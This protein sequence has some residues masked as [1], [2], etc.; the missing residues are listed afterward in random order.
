MIALLYANFFKKFEHLRN[1]Q[2]NFPAEYSREDYGENLVM[3]SPLSL[4]YQWLVLLGLSASPPPSS[5]S[6]LTLENIIA[7]ACSKI[8]A[9]DWFYRL[10]Q[11]LSSFNLT[12]QSP[13]LLSDNPI[14][15]TI[16]AQDLF[17]NQITN[18]LP[19]FNSERLTSLT[20]SNEFLGISLDDEILDL[21][22]LPYLKTFVISG[23]MLSR[24]NTPTR[25]SQ[26]LS[27]ILRHHTTL[28]KLGLDRCCIRANSGGGWSDVYKRIEESMES[29]IY[30]QADFAEGSSGYLGRHV[31]MQI[32]RYV[33]PYS[34]YFPSMGVS[35]PE[36]LAENETIGN[37]AEYLEIWREDVV[38]RGK[39]LDRLGKGHS[40]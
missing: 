18:L 33:D 14:P 29:L 2:V 4:D 1:L 20:I 13:V 17:W 10:L 38:A 37:R 19:A 12:T 35:D 34:Q 22:Y 7:W 32:G 26:T 5:F 6:N 23:F 15:D 28:E 21:V 8:Y 25:G 31:D 27:F 9:S 3:R 30:F 16:I 40:L 24:V 11:N 36:D 39:L